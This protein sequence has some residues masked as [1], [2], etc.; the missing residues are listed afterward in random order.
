MG[1]AAYHALRPIIAN[2]GAGVSCFCKTS[3]S[4]F[5]LALPSLDISA[6]VNLSAS[7]KAA[8]ALDAW[9][10]ARAGVTGLNPGWPAL[11]LPQ[12]NL[13]ANA[14]MSMALLTQLR[15]QVLARLGLDLTIAGQATA[16]ARIA[17]TLDARI[18]AMAA[19]GI[20]LN[21]NLAPWLQLAQL[22][23]A[24][25]RIQAA[26][27]AG[28]FATIN[29]NASA[30][31]SL[32]AGFGPFFAR[33][34]PLA[35]LLSASASAHLNA[36][37][38]AQMSASLRALASIRL[39][40][41]PSL[42][43]TAMCQLSAGLSAIAQLRLAFGVDPI[44]LGFPAIR[45]MVGATMTA[46][47]AMLARLGIHLSA[48]L[49]ESLALGMPGLPIPSFA[50]NAVVQAV[51]ALDLTAVASLNLNALASANLMSGLGASALAINL[52]EALNLSA[53]LA[54][55]GVCDAGAIMASMRASAA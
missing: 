34:T 6:A 35:M 30:A 7:A 24:L 18:S 43:L 32:S 48:N 3:M 4:A 5:S 29:L 1:N 39:P 52:S 27:S 14:I 12:I 26:V 25:L 20:N 15:A 45:A 23:A 2:P 8:M 9:L 44:K 17:A 16:F 38:I 19:M 33:L 53:A 55:C 50:I 11:P 21:I 47:I 36:A 22:N 51:M 37:A 10:T 49:S 40:S 41:L 46:T 42:N 28:L 13:S 54:P 31:L